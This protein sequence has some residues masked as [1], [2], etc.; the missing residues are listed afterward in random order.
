MRGNNLGSIHLEGF[1]SFHPK[2]LG[3]EKCR[4]DIAVG[5][6]GFTVAVKVNKAVSVEGLV[7]EEGEELGCFGLGVFTFG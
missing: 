6:P 1:I 2:T 7:V 3:L 4:T 5:D